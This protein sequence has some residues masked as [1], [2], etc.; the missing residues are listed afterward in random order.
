MM[1]IRDGDIF[2]WRYRSDEKHNESY[3]YWCCTRR[4]V[5]KNGWV[6]DIYW[7]DGGHRG[8]YRWEDAE[9]HLILKKIANFDELE[10]IERHHVIYYRDEDIVDM[11]HVNSYHAKVYKRK[12]ASRDQGVMLELAK[13]T[14]E[15]WARKAE[16]ASEYSKEASEIVKKI[17]SGANL[18]DIYIHTDR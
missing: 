9:K 15:N 11:R 3:A 17:E 2:E 16:S 14:A 13:R 1:E 5:A 12:G 6:N 7:S 10:E 8:S 4:C 18:D